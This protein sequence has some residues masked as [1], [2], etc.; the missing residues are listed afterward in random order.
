MDVEDLNDAW[1]RKVKDIHLEAIQKC[2][3]QHR[4]ET[5]DRRKLFWLYAMKQEIDHFAK[6]FILARGIQIDDGDPDLKMCQAIY[7]KINSDA[8]EKML[9]VKAEIERQYGQ[10]L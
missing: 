10:S 7:Q 5:D 6:F 3:D 4:V 9:S 8:T 1:G 2:M